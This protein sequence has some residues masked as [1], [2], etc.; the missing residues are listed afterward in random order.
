M[1]DTHLV[2]EADPKGPLGIQRDRSWTGDNQNCAMIF[3]RGEVLQMIDANQADVGC[4]HLI[5]TF[6]RSGSGRGPMSL[7][8]IR[9]EWH[10]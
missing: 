10:P 7:T 6:A 1:L 8:W 4:A 9:V 5:G 3:T 2:V